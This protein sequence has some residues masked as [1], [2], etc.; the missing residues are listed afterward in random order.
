MRWIIAA[1]LK[2]RLLVVPVAAGLMLIGVAQLRHAPVDV[3]PEFTP[4]LVDIQTEALGLS[5]AEVEQLVTVPLEQDLL[6]GVAFLDQ[7][8]SQSLPGLSRIELIFQ[9]GTDVLKARQLVAER[10]IQA[11]GGI[12]NVS[13]APVMLQPLSSTSRVMTVGLSSRSVSLI[14]MSVLAHWKIRPR[15]M[16]VPGVANVAVWGQR[17]KQLQVQ[18]DPRTLQAH[19]VS[20]E[21]V[22]STAGNALWVSPLSFVE[23]S[24]PGTGGFIDTPNQRLGIQ[25]ILPITTPANLSQVTVEGTGGTGSG[26]AG[27]GRAGDGRGA[28]PLRLGQVAQ[29][30]EDHQPLIGDALVGDGPSLM[31]VIEKFPGANTLEVT[32]GV[33]RA[34][35]DLQPGLS[36]ITVDPNLF[37]PASFIQAATRN[38]GLA[39]LLGLV[40]AVALLGAFLLEWRVALISLVTVPLSLLAAALVLYLRGATF[41]T[42]IL[43]GLVVALGVVVDDAVVDVDNVKRR[44]EGRRADDPDEEPAFVTVLRASLEV[45]TPLLYATLIVAVAAVPVLF[46]RGLTGSFVRQL[47]VSYLLAV[48]A[49]MLVALLVTPGLAL[50][51]LRQEPLRRRTSPVADWLGRAHGATLTRLIFR[52]ALGFAIVAVVALAGLAVLPAL[53]GRPLL[54]AMQ[55]RGLLVHWDA[56]PGMSQPEMDRITALATAE[57]RKLPGVRDVGAHVGRAITSDQVVDVNSGELWVT[58]DP[59]ADYGRTVAAVRRVVDGYPGLTHN[60]VTYPEERMHQVETG[61]TDPV[62]VRIFGGDLQVLRAKAEE[63]RRAIAT[64]PGIVAPRV[65]TQVMQP[66]VEIEVDLAKAQ[67]VGIKPGDVRREAAVLLSGVTVGS[68]FEEQKVFDVVVRGVPTTRGS[69]SDIQNLVIDRPDGGAVRLGDVASVRIAP[70]LGVIQHDAVSRYLDVIAGIH[71]RSLGAV[72]HDVQQRVRAVQFPLE[73]HAEVLGVAAQRQADRQRVLT[74]AVA[75]AIGILLLLQAAFGS[76]RLAGLL[77]ATVPL[78]LVGG[79]LA[80][81]AVSGA[82]GPGMTA[83]GSVVALFTVLGLAV[84]NGILL[85]TR[86][87]RLQHDEDEEFGAGLVLRGTRER[88][89]PVVLSA[90]AIGLPLVPALFLGDV[91]GLE[92]LR[93]LAVVILGGLVTATLVNLLLL[94]FLYLRLAPHPVEGPSP[95][96]QKR[97]RVGVAATLLLG[98]AALSLAAG[99]CSRGNVSTE[100]VSASAN[101]ARVEPVPGSEASKV[102]L[103]QDAVRRLGIQTSQV[104]ATPATSSAGAGLSG[105]TW[106]PYGALLYDQNGATWTFTNPAP[107]TYLRAKVSVDAIHGDQVLLKDGPPTGTTV[108]TVGATELL[109]AELGVGGE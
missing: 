19:G 57:L 25:H 67:R 41:N 9:P 69:L 32:R 30:V 40:V 66:T 4:P 85:V 80:A 8:R 16:S 65:N 36:G 63:I 46:L 96:S 102:I 3:L 78:A 14:D 1:S 56:A 70:N 18:V 90:L 12:P 43:A 92:V 26:R 73:H 75:A 34:L 59:G 17:E 86:F 64:V 7:I 84:R 20:L 58:L 29:V 83:L 72:T 39:A 93:P 55:D 100:A 81:L 88:L 5:A 23:A 91:A 82:G 79:V 71:G 44:L 108:V 89:G 37:R 97:A 22:I 52:P 74:V 45:R 99:G 68:L 15:L 107:L 101:A 95:M 62:V 38:L 98:L 28:A 47:A 87:Q 13:K 61:V 51:L 33:E 48:L 94:P 11:P 10:L 54:P 27:D 31:L 76:W 53:R 2:F 105:R 21:Q 50:L 42:M 35:N 24:T 77:F 49:S 104:Q 6:N 103:T 106:I 109:G 60:L